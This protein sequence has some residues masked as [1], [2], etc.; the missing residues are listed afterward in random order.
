MKDRNF[1]LQILISAVIPL[2]LGSSLIFVLSQFEERLPDWSYNFI[3]AAI[4]IVFIIIL[5]VLIIVLIQLAFSDPFTRLRKWLKKRSERKATRK[6][7]GDWLDKFGELW[8]LLGKVADND[9]EATEE[10]ERSYFRLHTWFR[11]RRSKFLPHWQ[12]FQERR[13]EPANVG[14]SLSTSDLEYVALHTHYKDS[15][16]VFYEPMTTKGLRQSLS[17]WQND[18]IKYVLVKLYELTE[19]FVTWT[20]SRQD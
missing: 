2:L 11:F 15:F 1:W 12:F 16:S 14:A 6:Q 5:A 18:E 10:Q 9:W 4:Y 13:T 17:R 3:I 19:E 7:I 20:L 8:Q